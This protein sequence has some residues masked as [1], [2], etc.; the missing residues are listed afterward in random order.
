MPRWAFLI[1]G[2]LEALYI[3]GVY[4]WAEYRDRAEN[5]Q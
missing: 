1:I 2:V 3:A 4:A 5:P